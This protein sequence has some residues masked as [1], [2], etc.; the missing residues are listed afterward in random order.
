MATT[1]ETTEGGGAE[2][3]LRDQLDQAFAETEGTDDAPPPPPPPAAG[4]EGEATPPPVAADG[5]RQRDPHGR[6][7][8]APAGAQEGAKTGQ[9]GTPAAQPGATPPAG[10]VVP[11][12]PEPKAPAAWKPEV[13]EKWA[14]AD[15][16]I[17]QEVTRREHEMQ[18]VLQ[19]SAA[20]RQFQ[21]AF[22]QVV[23]PYEM[24]MRAENA[25]PLQSV[26]NLMQTAA[27]LR[28]GTPQH[29]A[30]LVAGII[31]N[32]AVDVEMLDSIL[33]NMRQRGGIPQPGQSAQNFRDP[34]VD[35]LLA[36]Q[37][38]QAQQQ[39]EQSSQATRAELERFAADPKHEFYSDVSATMADIV[40]IRAK[41][42]QPVDLEK[43]YAQACAMNE[44]VSTVLATRASAAQATART[45]GNAQAVLR[46][47]RAAASVKGDTSL[48]GATVPANDS[49]RASIEAAFQSLGDT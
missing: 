20:A 30:N 33:S 45:A 29:K 41:Q 32:F 24:F 9:E 6:F 5:S 26:Q 34:R 28:V 40:E 21:N 49:I 37:Q 11:P 39:A 16:M 42:G 14:T 8:P 23:A 4:A 17:R 43:I 31:Q 22:Q 46:A 15:P 48:P 12:A 3:S 7:A 27:D 19:E 38:Q 35:M 10:A 1:T 2:L 25:S 44:S 13:R 47:K 18:T 36:Q